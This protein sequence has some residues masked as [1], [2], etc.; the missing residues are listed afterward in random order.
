MCEETTTL[1]KASRWL[2][3]GYCEP[4]MSTHTLGNGTAA[5]VANIVNV[6]A[7]PGSTTAVRSC[8]TQ[9]VPPKTS[10]L[11][12]NT[13]AGMSRWGRCDHGQREQPLHSSVIR[14]PL[15]D[16]RHPPS[17]PCGCPGYWLL[18]Q[19]MPGTSEQPGIQPAQPTSSCRPPRLQ[20][21]SASP[22]MGRE[23]C[24]R[25]SLLSL[26]LTLPCSLLSAS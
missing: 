12:N 19:A 6:Q 2:Q 3:I 14:S 8:H 11:Y 22:A 16:T 25:W 13:T 26:H 15:K 24:W 17:R 20:R 1:I 5:G 18:E 4:L 23:G 7:G 10:V 21:H 9:R